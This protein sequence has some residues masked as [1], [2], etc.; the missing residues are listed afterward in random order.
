MA[1]LGLLNHLDQLLLIQC[2]HWQRNPTHADIDP[3]RVS[4]G[5]GGP[6]YFDVNLLPDLGL[7][8]RTGHE[9]S[10]TFQLGIGSKLE[11]REGRQFFPSLSPSG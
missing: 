8:T 3:T 2:R 6:G 11:L 10:G 1:E 5:E 7:V 4:V 9:N